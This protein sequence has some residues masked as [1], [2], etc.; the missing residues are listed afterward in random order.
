MLASHCQCRCWGW[1]TLQ[2]LPRLALH[3]PAGHR[4]DRQGGQTL[5]GQPWPAPHCPPGCQGGCQAVAGLPLG[6]QRLCA[7]LQDLP[8]GRLHAGCLLGTPGLRAAR[9]DRSPALPQALPDQSGRALPAEAAGAAV[10]AQLPVSACPDHLQ[11]QAQGCTPLQLLVGRCAQHLCGLLP[12]T[13]QPQHLMVELPCTP[14]AHVG[15]AQ[16]LQHGCPEGALAQSLAAAAAAAAQQ[17][18]EWQLQHQHQLPGLSCRHLP[19]AAAAQLWD[20][21][22]Y[23]QPG[24]SCP[25]LPA[26]PAL[27]VS[28]PAAPPAG[29]HIDVIANG[30]SIGLIKTSCGCKHSSTCTARSDEQRIGRKQ[31]SC[32]ARLCRYA[33]CWTEAADPVET[34]QCLSG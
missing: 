33:S 25:P 5:E 27:S 32:H 16:L 28:A 2:G 31:L 22:R 29:D 11:S 34:L 7:A 14:Q 17:L 15:Y 23:Q 4:R 10:V 6:A 8:A 18:R 1:P 13:A 26:Q 19:P 24:L 3:C 21:Q 20:V 12:C 30:C 9:L